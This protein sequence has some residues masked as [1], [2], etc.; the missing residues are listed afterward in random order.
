[1]KTRAI[2]CDRVRK[3]YYKLPYVALGW[4]DTTWQTL[5]IYYKNKGGKNTKVPYTN[6]RHSKV[7]NI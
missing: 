6:I 4:T 3:L 7:R 2:L 1:M 5:C